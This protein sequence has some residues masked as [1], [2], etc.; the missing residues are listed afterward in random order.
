MK[1]FDHTD[2]DFMPPFEEQGHM[3]FCTCRSVCQGAYIALQLSVGMSIGRPDNV[4]STS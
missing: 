2:F 3:L 1:N 4:R